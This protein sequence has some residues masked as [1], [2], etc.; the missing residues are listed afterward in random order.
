MTRKLTVGAAKL[1][2]SPTPDMFPVPV[3]VPNAMYEEVKE[4]QDLHVR[5]I[6]ADNGEKRILFLA[7]EAGGVPF[8]EELLGYLKES[9]GFEP[10]DVL[11]SATHCHSM[12]RIDHGNNRMKYLDPASRTD[13]MGR[14]ATMVLQKAVEVVGLAL[15]TMRPAKVG[16]GEG[17]SYLN[18][19][20]DQLF[21]EGYWMQG[22]NWEGPSDKTLAVVEFKDEQDNV[23]AAILNYACHSITNFVQ[24]DFDGKY[25]VSGDF[26][27]VCCDWLER[28][29]GN[30]AIIAW[31]SG[32]AGNQNPVMA[33]G[34]R[35]YDLIGTNYSDFSS[36]AVGASYINCVTMG[37]QH[38]IDALKAMEKI[39]FFTSDPEIKT[40]D[41]QVCF[42]GQKFPEGIDRAK[43]RWMVDN[44]ALGLDGWKPGEP[45]HKELA[46]MIPTDDEIPARTQ[47]VVVGDTAFYGFNAELYNE[48][49]VLCKE[50]SPFKHT[51][52]TTHTGV[53]VGY[54]LDDASKDHKVF[55]YF[56]NIHHG[57][58]NRIVTDGMMA[59]FNRYYNGEE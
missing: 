43:H 54:I 34:G 46:E 16:Y 13:N 17:K 51:I 47:L 11:L 29:F 9:Y 50:V 55:Q 25:K 40:Y 10:Q 24:K 58:S 26:P 28:H 45:L 18:I 38:A 37:E 32:A 1:C 15:K 12:P 7:F 44:I 8:P 23:I 21:Y 6:V 49:G 56:G 3:A 53:S 30:G 52:V 22:Q 19:N 42:K 2:I 57:E 39:T 4:G 20:R 41:G 36:G 59:L 35:R 31:Q 27:A 14:F 48:I 5:A 33:F